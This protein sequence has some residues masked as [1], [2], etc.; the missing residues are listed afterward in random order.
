MINE[1]K[2]IWVN[3]DRFISTD[4]IKSDLFY[5]AQLDCILI[6][7]LMK[8]EK[9]LMGKQDNE[10]IENYKKK[11]MKFDI[12]DQKTLDAIIQTYLANN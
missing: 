5:W 1:A 11:L 2:K 4:K 3:C 8:S 6:C 12:I 10:L 9:L 7:F